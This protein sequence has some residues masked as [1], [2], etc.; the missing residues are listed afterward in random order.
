MELIKRGRCI[1]GQ[2]LHEGNEAYQHLMAELAYVPPESIGNTVRHY[3]EKLSSFSRPAER[4]YDSLDERYKAILRSKGRIQD[5]EDELQSISDQI[6]GK[7]NMRQYE[8]EV[9]ILLSVEKRGK[10]VNLPSVS[11]RH[12]KTA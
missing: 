1:C 5:W 4:T 3:R 10:T 6:S 8:S 12:I 7:E 9:E 11:A 2:E